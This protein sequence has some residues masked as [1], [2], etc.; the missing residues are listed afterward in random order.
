[1]VCRHFRICETSFAERKVGAGS[2]Q[3]GRISVF[4]AVRVASGVTILERFASD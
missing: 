3:L 1:M 4:S 2:T